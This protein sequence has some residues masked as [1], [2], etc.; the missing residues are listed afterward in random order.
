MAVE[1]KGNDG[2]RERLGRFEHWSTAVSMRYLFPL[3]FIIASC[4]TQYHCKKCIGN[5]NVIRDT[6]RIHDTLYV[7]NVAFDSVV[8]IVNKTDTLVIHKD[9][10]TIKYKWLSADTVY[11][12][13]ECESDTL[14][15]EKKIP[16][17]TEVRTGMG[18]GYV[19][20]LILAALL[21]GGFIVKLFS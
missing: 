5:G 19:I 11:L 6:L 14:Y 13:G 7:D 17:E 4:S 18:T 2:R 8:H 21:V 12:A 3:V 16:I 20:L 1:R 9:K 10:L 15:I